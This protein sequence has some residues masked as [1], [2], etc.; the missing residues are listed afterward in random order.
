MTSAAEQCTESLRRSL[1]SMSVGLKST[2]MS[3]TL[4]RA[5]A[6]D[7]SHSKNSRTRETDIVFFPGDLVR[8]R[9]V[10]ANKKEHPITY[11]TTPQ[12]FKAEHWKHRFEEDFAVV[13]YQVSGLSFMTTNGLF[14]HDC[15][16]QKVE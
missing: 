3:V 1:T 13:V 7:K 9:D 5:S 14:L 6:S 12:A 15:F 8:R 10:Y 4:L 2:E 16:F 11:M